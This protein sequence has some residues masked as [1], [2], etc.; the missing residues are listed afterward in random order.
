MKSPVTSDLDHE[1][2]SL[3]M[4]LLQ[5]FNLGKIV[6]KNR[7]VMAPMSL[8][9]CEDGYVTGRMIRFFEERARGGVGLI[10]LGDGVVDSPVGNNVRDAMAIDDDRYIP[11]LKELT[12]AVHRH[13]CKIA[14][15]L[16]HGGRRAGRVSSSG[17]LDVTR[18]RIPVAPSPLPHPVP[19]QV[20]PREL[21]VEEI[22][23]IVRKFGQAARRS[24][25]AGFDAVALHCAHMYLCGEFLSPW[26]NSR[27]D[28]YGGDLDGRLKFVLDVIAEMR[29][30][31]GADI[32]VMVRMNGQEPEGGNTLSE[33]RTIASKFEAAGVDAIHVSV[34][35]G[36]PTQTPGLIPSV[37]AMRTEAGCIVHLAENI[38]QAVSIPVGAAN[39][40]GDVFVAEEVLQKG[41]ADLIAMGRPLIADPELP[42]KACQGRFDEILP[43][44][45]C[46]RGCLQN[47]L[48]KDL[49][50]ACSI[51][52][53]AGREAEAEL[54]LAARKK[55]VLVIGGGPA[56]LQAAITASERGHQV[57][58]L[59]KSEL[60]GQLCLA[61]KTPGKG[62]VGDYVQ[63]LIN[64]LSRLN[65]QVRKTEFLSEELISE[66][67]PDAVVF[68]AGS[69]E[70]QVNIP[71]M[72]KNRVISA[73]R[74]LQSDVSAERAVIIGGGQVGSEVAEYL[75]LRG[76]AVTIIEIAEDIAGD[77]DRINRL[78]LLSALCDNK[79]EVLTKASADEVTEQGVWVTHLGARQFIAADLIVIAVGAEANITD[80][81]RVIAEKVAEK[82]FIGDRVFPGGILEAVH[83]GFEAARSI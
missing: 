38:K 3:I 32:P 34:G 60:G 59:E 39:K 7:I 44:I 29:K 77:M 28:E 57:V 19:G 16:S 52:P 74:I 9:L 21:T 53:F 33:I 68:A 58:L 20:V 14:M 67:N 46:C 6:L 11:A 78:A 13:D 63:Y 54:G 61:S 24:I 51:N 22:H 31:T 79:V 1:G 41:R 55:K 69:R 18:G 15:Q 4:K 26:A 83:S 65:I 70:R 10:L 64:S 45:G 5:P 36:S 72:E 71:G 17:F 2:K 75:S 50:V 76:T 12:D 40:L 25:I 48:E 73:R 66:I 56:G 30:N 49:P 8:N 81:E 47:I 80:D 35:F 27:Q 37:T 42:N 82:Y 43:C 62:V 23:E